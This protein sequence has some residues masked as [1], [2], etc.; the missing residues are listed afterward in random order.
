MM[1]EES[2]EVV[3]PSKRSNILLAVKLALADKIAETGFAY[4]G[5]NAER[6]YN[7]NRI[8]FNNIVRF[9]REDG[10]TPHYLELEKPDTE[11]SEMI[12]V[13]VLARPGS[14]YRDA[15]NSRDL[16]LKMWADAQ[17]PSKS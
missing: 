15:W 10:Y 11:V 17:I 8:R 4:V 3:S 14:T 12:L 2:P 5:P 1:T 13:K 7:L 6:S 9:L 16:I